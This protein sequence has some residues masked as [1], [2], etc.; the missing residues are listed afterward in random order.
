LGAAAA[1]G[2]GCQVG[3]EGGEA[4]GSSDAAAARD[5]GTDSGDATTV[6]VGAVDAG[7]VDTATDALDRAFGDVAMDTSLTIESGTEGGSFDS[8]RV[9]D[10]E[11]AQ[12]AGNDGAAAATD[13]LSLSS[14]SFSF[15]ALCGSTPPQ[16]SLTITNV[17]GAPATWL[18]ASAGALGKTTP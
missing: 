13:P 2:A 11:D 18:A 12:E 9:A 10:A 15:T 7:T 1:C 8:R 6:D 16:A 3:G 5:S 17:S 4:D 14:T